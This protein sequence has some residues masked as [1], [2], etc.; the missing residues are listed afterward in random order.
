MSIPSNDT[1]SREQRLEAVLLAYLQAIDAGKA[2]DREALVRQHPDL[3]DDLR[4]Y[5]TDQDRVE[6][7]ARP[8]RGEGPAPLGRVPYFGDYEL[9]EEVARGGMGVVYKARQR[10]LGRVVALKMIRAG[11]LAAPVDVQRFRTEAQ[12]AANLDHPN[13][14]PIYEVGDHQG[15][16]YF[17][18]KLFSEGSLAKHLPRL[19]EDP[20]A[21]VRILA[22]VA[23]AVHHAHQRGLL[24]RDLKPGNVLLDARDQPHVSD[25]GLAKC[26]VGSDDPEAA[27]L[28]ETGAVVGTPSYMAPEQATGTTKR[29]SPAAD[30][31][32][33]GAILYECLTGRPPFRA[34]TPMGTLLMVLHQEPPR[35]RSLNPKADRDLETVCLKC[36]EKDPARRYPSAEA[37]ADDL[38]AWLDGRPI[39]ARRGGVGERVVK[40]CRRRPAGAALLG[41]AVLGLSLALVVAGC[42]ALLVLVQAQRARMM[43]EMARAERDRAEE[44][45]MRARDAEEQAR[46]EALAQKEMAEH[47]RMMTERAL[48][49]HQIELAQREW[50][51]G[52]GRR[53]RE[54][55]DQVGPL[56]PR[57]WEWQYLRGVAQLAGQESRTLKGPKG[58]GQLAFSPDGSRIATASQDGK[59]QVWDV[60]S[61]KEEATAEGHRDGANCVAF[62]PDG[63]RLAS[64]GKDR[65]VRFWDAT[66]G[67]ETLRAL[68]TTGEVLGVAFSPDGSL[69]AAAA[70]GKDD[71]G[72][73]RVWRG[74]TGKMVLSFDALKAPAAGV[75]FS[76]NGKRLAVAVRDGTVKAWEVATGKD[77]YTIRAHEGAAE[78]VAFG[79][80]GRLASAGADKLVKVWDAATGQPAFTVRD[81]AD[82]VLGV[83]WSPD[84]KRLASVG[85]DDTVRVWDADTGHL[86]LTFKDS[87]LS[88]AWSPDGRLLASF[89]RDGAVKVWEGSAGDGKK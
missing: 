6:Q 34:E 33:L 66:S 29:L 1:I 38:E 16:H 77:L 55:L 54:L 89:T 47:Q 37:L 84:G 88:V 82:A 49:A 28:T 73:V 72:E 2:P 46:M 3:A 32:S 27:G 51:A 23:R 30:T 50:E 20:K 42:F 81:H 68:D 83:A 9:L 58:G 43:E 71:S 15:Q 52:Q 78:A 62:S 19:R 5:F 36:L 45:A 60:A 87:H 63:T 64:G 67:K 75:A 31:Y 10:R 80:E 24:H 7:L 53:A 14:V 17:S 74:A 39:K 61:G 26:V 12:A 48:Y 65:A 86:L 21:A 35:P 41:M 25:F 18:M 70:R 11:H 79:A 57:G 13:V 59:V 85:R 44:Q 40:W 56:P 8:L 76:L 22:A 69:V 4:A